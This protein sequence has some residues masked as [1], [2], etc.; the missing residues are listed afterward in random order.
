MASRVEE[1]AE[2]RWERELR[3][4]P[5]QGLMAVRL[6]LASAIDQGSAQSLDRA[7]IESVRQI[8]EE[9]ATIRA[10]MAEMRAPEDPPRSR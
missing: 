2:T 8:D 5:L 3:D 4:G 10:M 9:I 1:R 6:L 7:A